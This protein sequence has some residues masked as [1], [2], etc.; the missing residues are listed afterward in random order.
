MPCSTTTTFLE[1]PARSKKVEKIRTIAKE[2]GKEREN[3]N[4]ANQS[5]LKSQ[6]FLPL[7]GELDVMFSFKKWKLF[8]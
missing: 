3:G 5:P 4:D 7:G 2:R 1:V 6:A 8:Q